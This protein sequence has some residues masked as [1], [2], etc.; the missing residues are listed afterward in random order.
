VPPVPPVAPPPDGDVVEPVGALP[1]LEAAGVVEAGVTGAEAPALVDVEDELE[2]ELEPDD[3]GSCAALLGAE[4]GTVNEGAPAVLVV[5]ELP[6][7]QAAR[8]IVINRVAA[9][10]VATLG[11]F[12]R[13]SI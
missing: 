8:M 1:P 10:A 5:P 6:L 13:G 4:V 11:V 12:T 9:N 2:L 7:P 3:A